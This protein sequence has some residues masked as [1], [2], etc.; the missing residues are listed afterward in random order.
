MR[1]VPVVILGLITLF[2]GPSFS[3]GTDSV[4]N[5]FHVSGAVTV[6]NNGIS[7]IPTFTLG[8][9]AVIFDASFGKRLSFDPELK[10]SLEGKPWGFIFWWRYKLVNSEK[11]HVG[12]GAHPAVTYNTA[13]IT[14]NGVTREIIQARRYVATEFSPNYMLSKNTSVGFYYLY[15]HCLEND[16]IRDSH[17]ITFNFN[18]SDIRISGNYF[19]QF[20]PQLYYLKMDHTHGYYFTSSLGLERKNFPLSISGIINKPLHTDIVGGNDFV[21]NASLIY[22]FNNNYIGM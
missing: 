9:P 19:L 12:I 11:F 20:N 21:W 4:K 8:K 3:Q 2:S 10:Y 15:G 7:L 13:S 5:F 18:F 22:S 17:F 14:L 6:T 1:I 16:A